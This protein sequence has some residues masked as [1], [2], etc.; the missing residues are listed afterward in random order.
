MLYPQKIATLHV[1][2]LG[3]EL[4]LYDWQR[5]EVHTLNSTAALIWE[6]CD[7]QTSPT[8]MAEKLQAE[9]NAP[10]AEVLVWLTLARLE[11]AHLLREAVVKPTGHKT[12]TRR[13]L[14][15][16]LGVAAVLLPVVSSIVAPGPVE[17]QSPLPT[18][19]P[20]PGPNFQIQGPGNHSVQAGTLIGLVH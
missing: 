20:T 11:K 4:C 18:A 13:E 16:G 10:Q 14:L 9:L 17:A 12:L 8:Q 2:K 1:E 6:L 15:K 7:G 3:N 5:M 19:T